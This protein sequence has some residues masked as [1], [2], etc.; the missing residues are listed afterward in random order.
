MATCLVTGGAGFIG[1][2]VARHLLKSDHKTVVLDDLSGGFRENVPEG[3]LFVEGSILDVALVERLFAEHRF[4]YVYHLAAYAAEG[5]SHF[6]RRFNYHN[7]LIGSVNLINAS[8]NHQVKCFVFTSSIAV[9]GAGQSPMT[10][11]MVPIPEDPYGIAK[12]AVE[13]DLRASHEMFGMDYIIFRPH[14]VYGEGQNIGDRYRNVVGIFMNQLLKGEPMTI[15][16]D[17]EQQRAFTHIDDVAPIIADSVDVP[18]ARNEIFNV[19]ADVPFTVNRL[20]EVVAKAMGVPCKVKHLDPRNEVKVAFSDHSKAAKVFGDGRKIS[21]EEGIRRMA[22]WVKRHGA[23][24][25]SRFKD[26]EV[27]KNMPKSWLDACA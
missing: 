3:A 18:A 17:G 2:H 14:N 12:L 11:K 6:I 19:G 15:F 7:N 22:E 27:M 16:G 1:S 8:V 10:E 24:E 4:D 21:L 23:R 5:L 20:A 26:I 9:Y 25:S 13:Q